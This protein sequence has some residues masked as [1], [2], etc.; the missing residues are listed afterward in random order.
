MKITDISG[1]TTL[2]NGIKM[3]YLGIGCLSV[4]EGDEIIQTVKFA[5]DA[6]Y[7]HIDTAS[8]YKNE[9]GVGRGIRES[10]IQRKKIFCRK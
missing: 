3:P 4:N 10:G 1:T 8:N 2:A 9:K 6:G 7:R 5:L